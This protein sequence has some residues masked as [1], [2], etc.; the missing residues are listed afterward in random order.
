MVRRRNTGVATVSTYEFNEAKMG[1]LLVH[2]FQGPT[3]EWLHFVAENRRNVYRGVKYDL[4]AG[5]AT[6]DRT[7][8]VIGSYMAGNIDDE[9]APALLMPQKFDDQFA[10]LTYKALALP[11]FVKEEIVEQ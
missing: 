6:N 4:V 7:M 11:R 10:F 8:A 3:R 1:D 5:P 9:T 2:E